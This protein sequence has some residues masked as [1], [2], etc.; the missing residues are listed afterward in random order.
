ME[1]AAEAVRGMIEKVTRGL[2]HAPLHDAAGQ[3]ALRA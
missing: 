3:P 2:G 1:G